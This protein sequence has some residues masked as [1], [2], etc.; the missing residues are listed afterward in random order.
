VGI[1]QG[2]KEMVAPSDDFSSALIWRG[3]VLQRFS[4]GSLYLYD[5]L[6]RVFMRTAIIICTHKGVESMDRFLTG[7]QNWVQAPEDIIF[8]DN[9][10]KEGL[11]TAVSARFPQMTILRLSEN[12]M[13]CGGYNAGIRV[14][15]E[16]GYDFVLLSNADAEPFNPGMLGELLLAA[17]RWPRGAFFGPLV[18]WK[19][20]GTVQKTCLRFPSFLENT[21]RWL[22]WRISRSLF[23]RQ[24]EREGAV[25]FLNGVC[26]LC[27]VQAL[28]EVGLMD[29]VMG[30]YM[31]D[32]DWSW[33][34]RQRGWQSVFLPV[35]SVIHHEAATG[36][37]PYAL[38]SFLLK[39]NMV[40]WFLKIGKGS[41]AY[42]YARGSTLLAFLRYWRA[43][44]HEKPKHQ[45]FL[46]KMIRAFSGLLRGEPLGDWFG[47]PLGRW[48]NN[49][50]R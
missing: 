35:P 16:R 13:F 8:V 47:P 4:G 23:N 3:H 10:S 33:R 18:F 19:N 5:I 27:R 11:H 14:A 38:K 40:Y 34:A 36:Y 45:Y 39:R 41:S 2:A 9:G 21:W 25:E 50:G 6:R 46:K 37:E 26:L 24:P 30:G 29:E 32:A 20:Q 22:P 28:H 15:M 12:R 42:G 7:F 31:E 48:E 44:A 1:P 43:P 49:G 17:R